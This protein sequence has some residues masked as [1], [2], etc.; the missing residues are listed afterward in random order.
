MSTPKP[1]KNAAP[2]PQKSGDEAAKSQRHVLHEAGGAAGGA[3]AGAALGAI[4]GPAGAAAGAVIGGAVGAVVAKVADDEAERASLHDAEL[5]EAIGVTGGDIGAPN[6]KHPPAKRGT[7]S[8]ASAGGGGGGGG[9]S[10]AD[11]PMQ[12]P[13]D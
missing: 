2:R 4:A 6:L 12:A 5:D 9:G 13:E 3:L 7:F 8:S 10:T 1:T 11:G